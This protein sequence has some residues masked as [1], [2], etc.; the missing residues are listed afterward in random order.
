MHGTEGE[1]WGLVGLKAFRLRPECACCNENRQR[2][3]IQRIKVNGVAGQVWLPR[4]AVCLLF[5][6]DALT[7][8]LSDVM[9]MLWSLDKVGCGVVTGTARLC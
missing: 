1:A 3:A 2:R 7:S 8:G 4:D 6:A 5:G 9:V